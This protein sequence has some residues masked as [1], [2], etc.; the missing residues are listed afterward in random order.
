MVL[1]KIKISV[2]GA[3]MLSDPETPGIS[4]ET[5]GFE[6]SGRNSGYKPG[7]SGFGLLR[8]KLRVEARK[9]RI[10]GSGYSE[11]VPGYSGKC[12]PRY[13]GYIP[14]Y[15]GFLVSNLNGGECKIRFISFIFS[16]SI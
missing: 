11:K 3:K 10:W 14:G 2:F 15:S 12:C 1:P 13:S 6:H 5:P 16:C 4:P 9:L 8:G 7:Y